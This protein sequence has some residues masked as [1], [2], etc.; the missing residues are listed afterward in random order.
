MGKLFSYQNILFD[1]VPGQ[2]IAILANLHEISNYSAHPQALLSACCIGFWCILVYV[3]WSFLFLS[4]SIPV[5][6]VTPLVCI[7]LTRHCSHYSH[8]A[9]IL[10]QFGCRPFIP[11]FPYF[12]VSKSCYQEKRMCAA[13][14]CCDNFS[15]KVLMFLIEA[16]LKSAIKIFN[17][18]WQFSYAFKILGVFLLG[19][20]WNVTM[21][22]FNLK[23]V[24][25]LGGYGQI[26]EIFCSLAQGWMTV[27][28]DGSAVL[29]RTVIDCRVKMK[30]SYCRF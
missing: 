1:P 5:S 8:L 13:F 19:T 21:I 16:W 10:H 25:R 20:S 11:Y 4:L 22:L 7:L 12:Q 9:Q 14:W 2:I 28:Q 6:A 30:V 18:T 23:C 29:G 17:F 27:W 24:S 3:L 26:P 15:S